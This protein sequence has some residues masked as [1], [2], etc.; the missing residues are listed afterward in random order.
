MSDT[1]NPKPP[2]NIIVDDLF[3]NKAK[4]NSTGETKAKYNKISKKT[5]LS[6]TKDALRVPSL[7]Q[8]A[9][10]HMKN[11]K[12]NT[13]KIVPYSASYSF[14]D[15]VNMESDIISSIIRRYGLTTDMRALLY[16]HLV[17]DE[18]TGFVINSTDTTGKQNNIIFLNIDSYWG[19]TRVPYYVVS[20]IDTNQH[21]Y[22]GTKWDAFYVLQDKKSGE[23]FLQSIFVQLT[24]FQTILNELGNVLD[25]INYPVT[26]R[27][28]DVKAHYEARSM[29]AARDGANFYGLIGREYKLGTKISQVL[30]AINNTNIPVS[31]LNI[32]EQAWSLEDIFRYVKKSEGRI[33]YENMST[34][35]F[36]SFDRSLNETISGLG[37]GATPIIEANGAFQTYRGY[38]TLSAFNENLY[39]SEITALMAEFDRLI[40]KTNTISNDFK[41]NFEFALSRDSSDTSG[42][43]ALAAREING[44]PDFELP[45]YSIGQMFGSTLGQYLSNGDEITGV[46]AGSVL[47]SVFFNVGQAME[48]SRGAQIIVGRPYEVN[49]NMVA[50]IAEKAEDVW[51]DFDTDLADMAFGAVVGSV[52][53]YL[54]AELASAI[55]LKGFGAELFNTVGSTLLQ[56]AITNLASGYNAV[57]GLKLE[58]EIW[59]GEGAK[60]GAA[61]GA[62]L[63]AI[64]S[65][66]GTKLG[67]LIV[68]PTTTAG[69]VLGS[70]GSS[71]GVAYAVG[72][73]L[74]ATTAAATTTALATYTA[75]T[76]ATATTAAVAASS[77]LT[78][79][80]NLV[81]PGLGAFVGFVLGTLIGNL[82]GKKKPRLP[83]A[84]MNLS[85]VNGQ[86]E[87]GANAVANGGNLELAQYMATTA[88]ATLNGIVQTISA[89]QAQ[90]LPWLGTSFASFGHLNDQLYVK[91]GSISAAQTNVASADEA[92][93][94]MVLW[95]L[96]NLNIRGGNMFL[97]RAIKRN[98]ATSIAVLSGDMQIADDYGFYLQNRSIIDA[99]IAEPYTSMKLATKD[100]LKWV[101][102]NPTLLNEYKA[103]T[104]IADPNGKDLAKIRAWGEK[105]ATDTAATLS[106]SYNIAAEVDTNFYNANKSFM[107]R[108]MAKESVPL[109]AA[110]T[111]FYNNNKTQIDRIISRLALTQFAASW[112]ITL[113]RAAELNLNK[114]SSTDF[115][116]GAAGFADSLKLMSGSGEDPLFYDKIRF[117]AIDTNDTTKT[118]RVSYA[119][120]GTNRVRGADFSDGTKIVT[121]YNRL[122][123]GDFTKTIE[124]V[125]GESALVLSKTATYQGWSSTLAGSFIL[126]GGDN[127]QNR[128]SVKA[129]NQIAVS[130]DSKTYQTNGQVE[131]KVHFFD[132][133]GNVMGDYT[134]VIGGTIQTDRNWQNLKNMF[135]VPAGAMYASVEVFVK[136]AG[137]FT[138]QFQKA[139]FR[140]FQIEDMAPTATLADIPA[141]SG[142]SYSNFDLANFEQ[143]VQYA[144]YSE[145]ISS[146]ATTLQIGPGFF[147]ESNQYYN[148]SNSSQYITIKDYWEGWQEIPVWDEW[149]QTWILDGNSQW[150]TKSGGNDIFI[151]GSGADTLEGRNG[152]D[153]LDGGAG[154]DNLKGGN[155][156][157]TLLGREGADYLYG[158]A[159]DD[160]LSGGA[161]NDKMWG[162]AGNDVLVGGTGTDDQ[163]GEDGNDTFILDNDGVWNW[164][165]GGNG[166]DTA[167]F[168][169]LSAGVTYDLNPRDVD[170]RRYILNGAIYSV[171]NITGTNYDDTIYGDELTN[172]LSGAYGD[173]KLYGRAGNDTLNGG[174]GA[175][176]LDGGDGTDAVTYADSQAAVWVDLTPTVEN[177][178]AGEGFGGDAEGDTF[179]GIENIT[180]SALADTVKGTSAY[181][182][183]IGGK[184]DDWLI[185]TNGGDNYQGGD[186]FDTLDLS[187]LTVGSSVNL[188]STVRYTNYGTVGTNSAVWSGSY[189][190]YTGIEHIYGTD[191]VD[192]FYGSSGDETFTG[193]KGNDQIDGGEGNDTYIFN[194]GDGF[195]TYTETFNNS[196]SIVFGEGINWSQITFQTNYNNVGQSLWLSI[197]G[198][199]EGFVVYNNFTPSYTP[200]NKIKSIDVGGAGALDVT[201]INHGL[202]G[203]TG[204]DYV[205]G[206]TNTNDWQFG[207]EGDDIILGAATIAAEE[208]NNNI[209]VA[210]QGN[211]SIYTSV[212]D[213]TFVFER[214]DG[215]D[216]IDDKGGR[217]RI[218]IGSTATMDDVIYEVVG[219]DLYVGLKSI[220][221][222][223]QTAS[224][225]ADRIRI[226]NGGYRYVDYSWGTATGNTALSQ[227]LVEHVA[228]GGAEIDFKKLDVNWTDII[229]DVTYYGGGGDGGSY[230]MPPLVFD[231]GGDGLDLISNDESPVVFK[232]NVNSLIYQMGWVDGDD[233][234]LALDRN[235][236]GAIT[237]ISEI[238]FTSDLA[239]AK[240]DLEGLKAFDSNNDGILDKNDARWGEFR[241][242]RD[243]NQ[244]G[245]GRGKELQKLNKIGIT[246]ISLTGTPTGYTT[247]ESTGNVVINTTEFTWEDGTKGTAG[248]V[249]LKF[250]LAHLKGPEL[251]IGNTDWMY[252]GGDAEIGRAKT[253][254]KKSLEKV[255]ISRNGA[256][257]AQDLEFIRADAGDGE[258]DLK[259]VIKKKRTFAERAA[260]GNGNGA[261]GSAGNGAPIVIDLSNDG[262]ELINAKDSNVW[263]DLNEDGW[264][265]R[266][267][268]ASGSDGILAIDRDG[269]GL[270]Q[271]LS[272][273]SF[274]EDVDGATT[275]LEGLRAFDTNH[276]NWLSADDEKFGSFMIWQDSNE[277]GASDYEEMYS[278]DEI[279]IKRI[280]LIYDN[281]TSNQSEISLKT[282]QDSSEIIG[283]EPHMDFKGESADRLSINFEN[284][285]SPGAESSTL[286]TISSESSENQI[287]GHI[288]IEFKDGRRV[289]G[290]DVAFGSINGISIDP[291]ETVEDVKKI[292]LDSGYDALDFGQNWG[293]NAQRR[294]TLIKSLNKSNDNSSP[295]D[296]QTDTMSNSDNFDFIASSALGEI[297]SNATLPQVELL[298]ASVSDSA[299][300]S[301]RISP[302]TSVSSPDFGFGEENSEGA[303]ASAKKSR[304]WSQADKEF[305]NSMFASAAKRA[306]NQLEKQVPSIETNDNKNLQS[307][308]EELGI[309]NSLSFTQSIVQ[310]RSGKGMSNL[311]AGAGLE[312]TSKSI[313]ASRIQP[314]RLENGTI[315]VL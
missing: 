274:L 218:V 67:S 23:V 237:N 241:I 196:N 108:A 103:D 166:S 82:F 289:K 93:D 139:A 153:W 84:Y 281:Q 269:D 179:F 21:K 254:G 38:K 256:K 252:P 62:M 50:N 180:G 40:G 232:S 28:G 223:S 72:S 74:T 229:R 114:A 184:G 302:K 98:T 1:S 266:L 217:D 57:T 168:I 248:D 5:F 233:G 282:G 135:V 15:L 207:Y 16:G 9:E 134:K 183:L 149:S 162:G 96:N 187:E 26:N 133:N 200:N 109:N 104:T 158:E 36:S 312:A 171:E 188:S 112:I 161:D 52:S 221:N 172:V 126:N 240:T 268:W 94:K 291:F 277:D 257:V 222:P 164:M 113:Q 51:S 53:S 298:D 107:T 261:S 7:Y 242:W 148:Y 295:A 58:K 22:L 80:G 141:W 163:F 65:F 48:F 46:L 287:F 29:A 56:N 231:L 19:S 209:I 305:E 292:A 204:N 307:S 213:D 185:A 193:G 259:K 197:R 79:L 2:L 198:T 92:V 14:P 225:V 55:G 13:V 313:V 275:D 190:S 208:Q 205:Y 150:V 314:K 33:F 34:K 44:V 245:R 211:D 227:N 169:N 47:G 220:D 265:D 39:S 279:G 285:L 136:S 61:T 177:N 286:E 258:Q 24:P 78:A 12:T 247:K 41:L 226:L 284:T 37:Y 219:N 299:N 174:Q 69:A 138:S 70:L 315:G 71:L 246:S 143:D 192:Y 106:T 250:Q 301:E 182:V 118:L 311:N 137:A 146:T 63:S 189:A 260:D 88:K 278:L 125:D 228:A 86:F 267:G 300:L 167:S 173:D 124:N 120:G 194:I 293:L 157:D 155:G 181:N 59:F 30:G 151:T 97:K 20:S 128:Y 25:N 89:G 35:L 147:A 95:S 306:S 238:S 234:I 210:G 116:G 111:T 117:S 115:I 239:G 251:G 100:F 276:D 156:D 270:V 283:I 272:E 110:D 122:S 43:Y 244:N 195:D 102:D 64:G 10:K 199:N 215:F 203:G 105:K 130:F 66:L 280:G 123:P 230:Y 303:N 191:F 3:L 263:V 165:D 11:S 249:A 131:G 142:S 154:V 140:H 178:N 119:D 212:G 45:L 73:V 206:K 75:A 90:K 264:A 160:Y 4:K 202:A 176:I 273:I 99:A 144:S 224:Q 216:T 170:G 81:V 186:G 42:G 18:A 49:G 297:A 83:T 262:I 91:L 310:F 235:G 253:K 288:E 32:L 304:W 31:D 54:T 8:A 290:A 87:L 121:D 308:A 159:N 132:V 27:R 129:G 214:G 101:I 243:V 294:L 60:E 145:T 17:S 127:L 309:R 6:L 85:L 236:D 296:D 68:K 77:Q 201:Q 152:D 255:Q 271:D 175:D 76:A